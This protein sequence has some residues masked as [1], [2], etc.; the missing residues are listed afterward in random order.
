MR[1]LGFYRTFAVIAWGDHSKAVEYLDRK[2]KES[3]RG[4]DEPVL[5]AES[6]MLALLASLG[7]AK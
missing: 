3:P 7:G 5:A 1:T 4:E 2:I 6:Q